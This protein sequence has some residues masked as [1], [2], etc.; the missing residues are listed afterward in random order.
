MEKKKKTAIQFLLLPSIFL[1]LAML[2]L[3]PIDKAALVDLLFPSNAASYA[4][5]MELYQMVPFKWVLLL[6][7]TDTLFALTFYPGMALVSKWRA[8]QVLFVISGV[9]D[10]SE[11]CMSLYTYFTHNSVPFA[12]SLTNLKFVALGAALILAFLPNLSKRR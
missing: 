2:F 1:Y 5:V 3:I 7:I 12:A 9:S 6:F 4:E 10:I 11:N 8:V